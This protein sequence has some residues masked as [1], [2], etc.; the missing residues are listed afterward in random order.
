MTGSH[1]TSVL[2]TRLTKFFGIQHPIIL[3]PMTPAAG[4]V[5]AS[6]VSDAGALGLLGGGYGDRAWFEAETAKVTH[7]RVGCGFITWSVTPDVELFD[8]A[9]AQRPTAM[10]LSFGDPA[11][12]GAR[13][14]KLG[15]HLICQVHTIEHA[16]RAIDIGADVIVAQGT[17][18]GGHG[19]SVRSTMPFVPDVV[20]LC[21]TRSPKTLVAAAG[22]IADGRGLA[23]ALM[24]GADGVLMG[25]RFWATQEAL[26]HEDAK[27]RVVAASG[28][29]TIR[30][31]VY[32]VVR[33]RAW[34]FPYTGRLLRN[35]FV[36][37]WHGRE[38]ELGKI[39][40]DQLQKV[41]AASVSGDHDTANVTVGEA[42]GLVRDLP[43][44]RELI[45]SVVAQ[46][47]NRLS[48]SSDLIRTADASLR[49]VK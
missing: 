3:A 7:P 36:E 5:L 10:M 15:V 47:V 30:T 41:E 43:T 37:E 23:A 13:V 20:D 48:A 26:I 35:K 17:E 6:A 45:D 8:R 21:A 11:S 44:A 32:D 4:G 38:D 46:A 1:A 49:R 2:T 16:K 18:A 28:D 24:L 42:I 14:K 19:F 40:A 29:D 22:G 9:L 39:Q 25:T 27:A 34:P 12:L 33:Q 31:T